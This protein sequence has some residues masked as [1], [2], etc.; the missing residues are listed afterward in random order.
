MTDIDLDN[1]L[2]ETRVAIR[3]L[4]DIEIDDKFAEVSIG[5]ILSEINVESK[6]MIISSDRVR[7]VKRIEAVSAN[8]L[9]TVKFLRSLDQKLSKLNLYKDYIRP[10][11]KKRIGSLYD[12]KIVSGKDLLSLEG[13]EFVDAIYKTLLKREADDQGKRNALRYL[14]ETGS[15]KVDLIYS[16]INSEEGKTK[17]IRVKGIQAR[18]LYLSIKR[19]IFNIPVLG[20]FIRLGINICLLPRRLRTFQNAFNGI[21]IKLSSFDE[22]LYK[23][24]ENLYKFDG[25]LDKFNKRLNDMGQDINCLDEV[26]KEVVQFK[27]RLENLEL[28]N[29]DRL[30]IEKDWMDK[31]YVRYNEVL[32]P[33]SREDVKSRAKIYIDKINYYFKD[34]DKSEL[35]IIDLG[36]GECEWVELLGEEGYKA[37]GIDSNSYVINKVRETVPDIDIIESDALTYLNGL[38]D[39]SVDI[40]S[41]LHMVEHMEMIEIIELLAECRRVLK[42]GGFLII[43]TP[44]PQNIMISTY[45]FNIDPTHKKPIP[46]ELLAFVV[47]ESGLTVKEKILLYPLNFTPYEY[48][49]DDPLSDIVFRFNMEQ[50]YSV[51][52][53]KEL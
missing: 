21:Y 23:L 12:R 9:Q 36:C 28:N 22:K 45:Y 18:K 42:I 6:S 13:E 34:R 24:D 47:G 20:Y 17:N 1:V 52:A 14:R 16:L 15:D 26:S 50:A 43:E 30:K 10:E 35:V 4:S 27:S 48:K 5:K 44:N 49:K 2:I 7:A 31:F 46:P 37:T 8:E 38:E 39:D 41:S 32:M 11:I 19:G 53:V 29:S 25:E 40:L 33:D 51:L 3:A